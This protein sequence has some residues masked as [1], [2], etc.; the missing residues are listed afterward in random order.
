MQHR[1]S[2]DVGES[3][4]PSARPAWRADAPPIRSDPNPGILR[5]LLHGFYDLVWLCAALIASPWWGLRMLRNLEFRQMVAQRLALRALPTPIAGRRRVLVHGVSVGEIK[6]A[7]PLVARILA[8]FPNAEVVLSSTTSSGLAVA[9]QVFPEHTVVRFPFDM[10][11]V[12][13]KFLATLQPVCVVLMEL[14]IWPNFLRECNRRGVP[15]A[16]VNG[17]ITPKSFRRYRWFRHSLPQF[18]RIS[19][20]CVQSEDYAA[21]FS[22]LSRVPERVLVTG[23]MKADGLVIGARTAPAQ[24]SKL[25]GGRAGQKLIVAGSTHDPEETMIARAWLA[26]APAA[27]LI[28]VPRHPQRAQ[29]VIGALSNCG[30]APQLLSE[31]RKGETPDPQRPAIVDT[32]GELESV[33]ALADLVYVG[34][35]LVAHGGQNMLEPAAQGKAVVYG[36]HVDNFLSEAALLEEAGASRRVSGGHALERAFRELTGDDETRTRMG[37]AGLS[38]V[39][40][41]KGATAL[42]LSALARLIAP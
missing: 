2:P 29:D 13:G 10:S 6:G 31:L 17:R 12:A 35:S 1:R 19:L 5:W 41:Q 27:R 28:L 39:E 32:I 34:G 7:A 11:F 23:S 15:V 20:F 3:L 24:L 36:P 4:A 37:Q 42:T 8:E 18:N 22:A 21:R 38:V 16:V 25:L 33:Y 30:A 40:R 26:G 14:E 9:R